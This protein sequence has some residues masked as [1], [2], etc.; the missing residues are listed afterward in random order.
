MIGRGTFAKV[1]LSRDLKTAQEYAVKTFDKK[2][3][4]SEKT[5]NKARVL[6]VDYLIID[7]TYQRDPFDDDVE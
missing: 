5:S 1:V 6:F 7:R 3:L 2:N 4:L